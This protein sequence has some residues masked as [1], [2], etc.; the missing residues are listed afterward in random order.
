MHNLGIIQNPTVNIFFNLLADFLCNCLFGILDYKMLPDLI[1][2][3]LDL[4]AP[5]L[6]TA[7]FLNIILQKIDGGIYLH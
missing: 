5:N 4:A 7:V 1:A 6:W 3:R 2:F